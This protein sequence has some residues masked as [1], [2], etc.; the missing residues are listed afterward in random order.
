[1]ARASGLRHHRSVSRDEL[2]AAA[3]P[4]RWLRTAATRARDVALL[5]AHSLW[6]GVV[7]VY[8]SDDLTHAASIAY[9]ALL[10]LFPFLLLV[11]S[12]IGSVT[13]DERA[14]N[15]ALGFVFRY[16]PTRL[17]FVTRQLSLFQDT[18]VGFG[19]F[20]SIALVW[21]SL[22]VFSAI[23]TAVNHAWRVEKQRSYLKHKLVS[24]LMLLATASVL[25]LAVVLISAAAVVR[26]QWFA[27]VA[28]NFPGLFAFQ[29]LGI[30]AGATVL[31]M[32][33]VGLIFY[34][35]P[36]A[37]V[38]FRD[39]WVGAVVT[40]LLWRGAFEGFSWYIRDVPRFTVHGSIA[41][42]VAFL[43]WI[44]IASVILLYGVEFTAAYSRMR[45]RRPD[46]VPAAPSPRV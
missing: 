3:I 24:F 46:T 17:E 25:L 7:G 32:I 21:A 34:F 31:L 37:Q 40:G 18:R 30:R 9:Y 6:R 8:N 10:S 16:F 36:N 29:G 11:I 2:P 23:S 43:V 26:A 42:V 39:V 4:R 44:Y 28:L 14:R 13:A 1:V 5:T 38:R 15:E 12:V 27:H 19:V 35:I 20:G 22:G 41:T 33:A 45:R